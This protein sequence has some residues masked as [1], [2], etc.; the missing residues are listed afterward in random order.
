M[1]EFLLIS[2]SIG[3]L[4]VCIA[5]FHL[6]YSTN[7]VINEWSDFWKNKEA[8]QFTPTVEEPTQ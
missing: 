8:E 1:K 3:T 4:I 6:C 2:V 7:K 5:F